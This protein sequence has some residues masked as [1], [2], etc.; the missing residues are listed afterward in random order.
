MTSFDKPVHVGMSAREYEEAVKMGGKTAPV[1]RP[2]E[3]PMP[4]DL[5][6]LERLRAEA[7]G[8]E[9][10]YVASTEHHGPYV[11]AFS[12]DIC[13]C[14]AMSNP[15][16]LSVRNGGTSR[17]VPHQGEKADAN[18]RFIAHAANELPAMIAEMRSMRER[19]SKAEEALAEERER[20]AKVIEDHPFPTQFS[21]ALWGIEKTMLAAAIRAQPPEQER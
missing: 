1:E 13:D 19:L 3:P 15:N 7:T 8:F 20:C 4:V 12:G 10:S 6:A 21:P 9:W 18:A 11:A 16:S 5:E 14:Y 2:Q 17:P